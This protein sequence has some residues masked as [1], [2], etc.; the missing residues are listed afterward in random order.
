MTQVR[1]EANAAPTLVLVSGNGSNLQAI[2]DACATGGP[3]AGHAK[4]IRVISNRKNAFALERATKAGIDTS[5]IT[6]K[7]YK[8]K[9][10]DDVQRAREEFDADLASLILQSQPKLVVC[11]GWMHILSAAALEP[12][13]A[14]GVGIINLH[15]ALPGQFDGARAIER[16]YEAFQ[17]GKIVSTGIMV[18][19]VTL[20]VDRGDPLITYPITMYKSDSIEDLETRIHAEEHKAIVEGVK[21]AL[22][23]I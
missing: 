13:A 23:K 18:H 12:L 2:I 3:L 15:P 22:D 20:K 5:V 11:A 1:S 8:L 7:G 14:A 9:H 21:L 10:F 4:V 16:A 6:L 19:W 17:S